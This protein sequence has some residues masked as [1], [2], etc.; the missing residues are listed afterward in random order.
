M[1]YFHENDVVTQLLF[2]VDADSLVDALDRSTRVAETVGFPALRVELND[3][4]NPERGPRYAS[5]AY[6]AVAP[7]PGHT[8]QEALLASAYPVLETYDFAADRYHMDDED[9]VQSALLFTEHRFLP[10]QG[11]TIISMSGGFGVRAVEEF[12]AADLPRCVPSPEEAERVHTTF[13]HSGD[14]PE[15]AMVRLHLWLPAGDLSTAIGLVREPVRRHDVAFVELLPAGKRP[16]DGYHAALLYPAPEVA[17]DDRPHTLRTAATAAARHLGLHVEEVSVEQCGGESIASVA[18]PLADSHLAEP[19]A[20]VAV[21]VRLGGDPLA[22]AG[23][24][25]Q[26]EE[27][28][29]PD[30]EL[31]PTSRSEKESAEFHQALQE[32]FEW[33]RVWIVA[34]AEVRCTDGATAEGVLWRCADEDLS[35]V[36]EEDIQGHPEGSSVLANGNHSARLSIRTFEDDPDGVLENLLTVLPTGT[37]QSETRPW[38]TERNKE[39]VLRWSPR[40]D[41]RTA[42]IAQLRVRVSRGVPSHLL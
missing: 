42:V 2:D 35:R 27:D 23:Q 25:E 12:H 11:V 41:E 39:V 33:D 30:V 1:V 13:E 29:E 40:R 34:D 18:R 22:L 9:G 15:Q 36:S 16:E 38:R 8:Q 20:V 6:S 17:N 4:Y 3:P 32:L 10:S 7:D 14:D 24:D 5:R 31:D 26:D 28:D 21:H 19:R 37:W